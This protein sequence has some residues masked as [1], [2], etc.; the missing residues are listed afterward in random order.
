MKKIF[1]GSARWMLEMIESGQAVTQKAWHQEGVQASEL[2]L[3]G[4]DVMLTSSTWKRKIKTYS[5]LVKEVEDGRAFPDGWMLVGEFLRHAQYKGIGY[6]RDGKIVH[7]TRGPV[8]AE[9]L[10]TGCCFSDGPM[11]LLNGKLIEYGG[12]ISMKDIVKYN[13]PDHEY[14]AKEAKTLLQAGYGVYHASTS[15]L[16]IAEEGK[17]K[18]PGITIS[19]KNWLSCAEKDGWKVDPE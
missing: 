1:D 15:W 11:R 14:T 7:V 12:G 5:E 17:V 19:Y 6:T 3:V 18:G 13:P 10:Y 16:W 9:H 4:N 8:F 2:E